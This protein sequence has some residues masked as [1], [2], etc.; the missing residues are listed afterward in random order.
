M[1]IQGY[2]YGCQARPATPFPIVWGVCGAALGLGVPGE[3]AA[4]QTCGQYVTAKAKQQDWGA[5]AL[6][7]GLVL[8]GLLIAALASG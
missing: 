1:T 8:A 2:G 3:E 4:R 7:I 5:V 6:G